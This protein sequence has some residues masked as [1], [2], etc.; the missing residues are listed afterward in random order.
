MVVSANSQTLRRN[1]KRYNDRVVF[2]NSSRRTVKYSPVSLFSL[3]FICALFIFS[4]YIN[5]SDSYWYI[6]SP[7]FTVNEILLPEETDRPGS[8]NY[9]LKAA[10]DLNTMI[11]QDQSFDYT[12]KKFYLKEYTVRDDDRYSIIANKFSIEL[13]SLLSVNDIKPMEK[14]IPGSEL[15]IPNISGIFYEVKKGDTLSSLASRFKLEIETIQEINELYSTVI[16]TGEKLFLP[17]IKMDNE[18]FDKIIGQN[19]LIPATGSVK[20]TYGS[21]LDTVTGLKNYN[22]GIDI[23][24]IKG[25]AVYASKN[26]VI[27]DTSYNSYYGRVIF[28]NHSSSFQSM[29]GCLNSIVVTPGQS[30]KRGEIIGYMGNSG[31]KSV[32]HLQFS[33]FKNKEDVDTLEYIF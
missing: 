19:F 24:N 9:T 27:K 18:K 8:D 29:Y 20:N 6:I 13:D 10:I 16:H 31:F 3:P 5:L 25:T 15:L 2:N 28:I 7:R 30:V 14:I 21:Y 12:E 22:Y 4:F 11:P 32:E 17:G 1:R 23:I 33:I 26:G